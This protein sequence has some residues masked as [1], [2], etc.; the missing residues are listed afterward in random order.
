M[1]A[2]AELPDKMMLLGYTDYLDACK[3][4]WGNRHRDEVEEVDGHDAI[5]TTGQAQ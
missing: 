4:L 5:D 1:S 3:A 2:L